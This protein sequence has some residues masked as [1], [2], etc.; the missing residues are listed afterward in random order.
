MKRIVVLAIL[1]LVLPIMGQTTAAQDA[2]ADTTRTAREPRKALVSSIIIGGGQAYNRAWIKMIGLIAAEI[3]FVNKFQENRDNVEE[4]R[5]EEPAATH[6]P[7]ITVRNKYAWWVVGTYLYAMVDA[8]VDAHLDSFPQDST[9]QIIID[10]N[11]GTE[12]Q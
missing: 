9:E 5:K 2:N 3:Y 6:N 7:Y 12:E 8:Y 11:T 1:L 10:E 4:F